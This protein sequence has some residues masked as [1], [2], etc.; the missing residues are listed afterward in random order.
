VAR[1]LANID[2]YSDRAVEIV[3]D[4]VH[5]SPRARKASNS[6][7]SAVVPEKRVFQEPSTRSA[8]LKFRRRLHRLAGKL[9]FIDQF[10]QCRPKSQQL[11][12]LRLASAERGLHKNKLQVRIDKDILSAK[13]LQ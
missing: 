3:R 5:G 8:K 11:S 9:L 10:P 2:T 1:V 4:G 13:A 7:S 12:E 6:D